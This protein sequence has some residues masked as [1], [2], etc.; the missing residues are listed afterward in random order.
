MEQI[1]LQKFLANSGICSRRKAEE[2]ILAGKVEVNGKTVTELGTK[3]DIEKDKVT[4]EGKPVSTVEEKVYIL[5][6]KPIGYV[7]TVKDQ[8]NRDTVLDLIKIKEKI[9]PVGR[10]DMYTSGALIL[11]NDGEFIYKVTHPKYEIEKAYNVTLKGKITKEEIE[12]LEK[13]VKI[14][15]YISGKAKVKILKIDEVKDISR[16]EI[17]IHEGKNREVRKMCNAIGKKVLALHRSRIGNIN[18]KDLKFTGGTI[19][20]LESIPGYTTNVDIETFKRN[21]KKIGISL[22]GQ[23]LNLAPAD[24]KIYALRDTI[25]C[26]ENMSLIASSIMSKKI[27]AGANKV[28]LDVTCGSGAFMKNEGDAI[29]L[30]TIMKKIGELADKETVCVITNMDEPLGKNVGNTLEI[31]E[32]IEALRGKMEEDVKQVVLELGAH[33]IKLAGKG[34]SI[35]E[36]KKKMLENIQNGKALEK[37]KQLIQNQN[38]DVLYI[39]EPEKFE[40]SKYV[41]S[42]ICEK[43]GYI[44][45][46][47]AEQIG[48]LSVFLGAG[49]IKKED[50]IDKTVGIVLEKK[51]GDK[52]YTGDVIAYIHAN[53][54]EKANEAVE[55]IKKIY[56]IE[57]KIPE[58]KKTIIKII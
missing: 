41:I 46:I 36:N 29:K 38:G 24:K 37:F 2:Y 26:V 12:M 13:G 22:I 31:L 32:V 17:T 51:V 7:T 30:S 23:T 58:I 56:K 28:V 35:E 21:V 53:D 11:S 25:S 5:L 44:T 40:K 16:I 15:D 18:V 43:D 42:V 27:A 50:E 19:D 52:V 45:S 9:V 8:F 3:I 14:D 48:R 33:M 4:F 47:D 57:N 20:K 54:K 1:R 49:R 34:N 55:R 39:D 6:N 10:L